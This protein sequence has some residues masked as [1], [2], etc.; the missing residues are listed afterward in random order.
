MAIFL[1]RKMVIYSRIIVFSW[2]R[3]SLVII[4]QALCLFDSMASQLVVRLN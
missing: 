2:M 4:L 3:G 1:S